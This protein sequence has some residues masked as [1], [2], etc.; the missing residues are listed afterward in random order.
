MN[1]PIS[2]PNSQQGS[3]LDLLSLVNFMFFFI[4]FLAVVTCIMLCVNDTWLYTWPTV[5]S[6]EENTH[7]R[8]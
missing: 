2:P 7:S 1:H 5:D 3:Y 4:P 8:L 6:S